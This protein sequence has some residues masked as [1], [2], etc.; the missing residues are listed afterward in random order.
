M[1]LASIARQVKELSQQVR[2][3]IMGEFNG[4]D[5][6]HVEYK[7]MND[8]VSYV[9]KTAEK[10]LVEKLSQIVPEAGFI[11]EEGT[12]EK[13]E[14]DW[15]WIVDPLDGTTNFIHGVPTFAISIAL[16]DEENVA[17]G[18]VHELNLD[19]CFYAYRGGGAYLN[20][21]PMMVSKQTK[22]KKG[23]VA[24]G[25]PFIDFV[26]MPQYMEILTDMMK[27]SHGLRRMGSAAVD[28]AYVAA[29]RFEGFF[30]YNLKPWDVAAGVIL[31]EEAGGN[32][33]DFKGG[34]DHIFGKEM[35]AAAPGVHADMLKVIQHWWFDKE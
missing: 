8:M 33:T 31:V 26:K 11:A 3:F 30:E 21:K 13:K 15:N 10:M 22:L 2:T 28:M 34:T 14:G 6:D 4:F 32:V 9:D 19:E 20:D 16:M 17:F 23:L 7:G 1:D 18:L 25:F 29:G 24:T 12:G 27:H 35:L 5:R